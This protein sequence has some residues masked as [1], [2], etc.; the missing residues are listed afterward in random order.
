MALAPTFNPNESIRR[1]V[2]TL[3]R[4]RAWKTLRSG[5]FL[6]GL[7]ELKE[8]V[9]QT[10]RRI[11]DIL[12]IVSNNQL[13]LDV[14]AVDE[15]ALIQGFQKIAN[16]ITVGVVL[17]SM[18]MG[19]SLMMDIE[20]RFQLFGYPGLPIILF[21]FAAICGVGLLYSIWRRDL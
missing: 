21:L 5:S 4:K 18:I 2:E 7:M 1:N 17:G 8:I 16:R 15:K 10:P 19:A 13:R 14:D 9:V 6:S 20:S 12:E 11:N 3:A